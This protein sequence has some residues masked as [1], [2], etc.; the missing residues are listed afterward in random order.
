MSNIEF[1]YLL[2]FNAGIEFERLLGS[3]SVF[4]VENISF[5]NISF[6]TKTWSMISAE[7]AI[8]PDP[9]HP[10]PTPNSFPKDVLGRKHRKIEISRIHFIK[11]CF[12][13]KV[14]NEKRFDSYTI[15][16]SCKNVLYRYILSM[17]KDGLCY[18]VLALS[19]ELWLA[20]ALARLS[21]ALPRSNPF[22]LIAREEI[23]EYHWRIS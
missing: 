15:L 11:W 6:E 9:N 1:V 3:V 8:I 14:Q 5:R 19:T 18:R 16:Y 20:V 2:N 23:Q 10:P 13:R 12:K 22:S 17:P 4:C 21:L 7:N